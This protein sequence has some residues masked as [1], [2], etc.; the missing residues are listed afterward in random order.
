M[1]T[2]SARGIIFNLNR[3]L[4]LKDPQNSSYG[5]KLLQNSVELI[6]KM[7]IEC[8]T[9]KKLA[10]A[11]SSTEA[12]VYRYFENKHKLLLYLTCWYWEWVHYLID[13]NIRNIEDPQKVLKITIHHIINASTESP[14][15]SY[16]NERLLHNVVIK[17]G[18]KAYHIHDVD[19]ENQSGFYSSYKGVV[20]KVASIIKNYDAS[21]PYPKMLASNLC[22]MANNQIFF[23]EHI[24]QLTDI[25]NR[26]KKYEDLEEALTLMVFRILEA[27]KN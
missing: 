9:F 4:Y 23:A 27:T 6:E 8:F 22:E 18:T 10:T 2:S 26:K 14:L 12:S 13:L 1:T 3:D 15:T 16:I 21:F 19:D 17:E 7:G 25:A 24:P 20:S 5:Q 11:I